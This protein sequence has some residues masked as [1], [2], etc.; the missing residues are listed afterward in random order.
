L[1]SNSVSHIVLFSGG[2]AS[3][4][5]GRR[6]I[7]LYGR[8]KVRFWFFDTL[9]E[10]EGLYRFLDDAQAVFGAQI[11]R[12]ADG[13]DPWQVFRDERF[14]GNSRVPLCNRVL[15]REFL[16][17]FL[18]TQFPD[19]DVV[20]H[21]GLEWFERGRIS[22][23]RERWTAKGYEVG[24]PL[25]EPPLL[26]SQDLQVLVRRAGL[27]VPRLYR[28]GFKH[29]NCGGACVQA[30][31][32]QW[33]LLWRLF[34]ERYLWHEEQEQATRAYLNKDVAILRDRSRGRTRP[35]TLCELRSRMEGS[36]R[37][38]HERSSSTQCLFT[39]PAALR[40]EEVHNE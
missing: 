31:I 39:L 8:E 34:P 3:F 25:Q 27:E 26:S 2:L 38:V 40:A 6:V 18:R 33:S 13:R 11:E 5:M 24:F 16:E 29:N 14:I 30:G 20:L 35:L 17:R 4:E 15:K 1:R 21:F 36:G 23:V 7:T 19:K 9:V 37:W 10:D 12:M 32:G 22:R 28:V